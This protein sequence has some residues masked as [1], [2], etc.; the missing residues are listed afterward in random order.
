[1][2]VFDLLYNNSKAS[3]DLWKEYTSA[4]IKIGLN[5][6]I[7]KGN[8][9]F[10][11][12]NEPAKSREVFLT[13][14]YMYYISDQGSII[15]A[16]LK[17]RLIES[18]YEESSAGDKQFG[19][20]VFAG[21][22]R[23]DFYTRTSD[24]LNHWLSQLSNVAIMADFDSEYVCIKQIDA[25]QYGEVFLCQ[26][27]I[28]KEYYAVKKINKN[29]FSNPKALKFLYN[30]IGIMRKLDH[31]NIVKLYKV[32]EDNGFVYMIMEYCPHGNLLK[33]INQCKVFTERESMVFIKNLLE[34]L[35]YLHDKGIIH[36]DLKPE[37]I[38]M[39][40]K[41][42]IYTFK[43]ADFGLSCY[44]DASEKTCSGSPGYMAPEILRGINYST[45]ADIFSAGVIAHIL[46][47]GI[48]PFMAKS[49][50][51]VIE[52]NARCRIM[53][54]LPSFRRLS[55]MAIEFLQE[56]LC[57]DPASR[58]SADQ[59]MKNDWLKI[60]KCSDS[61]ATTATLAKN[62]CF[63]YRDLGNFSIGIDKCVKN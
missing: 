60:R 54:N 58:P 41:N 56:L 18:F 49:S 16:S 42:S 19:F 53:F 15:K 25:G 2:S 3:D 44:L 24:G 5:P 14:S 13:T 28:T 31:E 45:K 57:A 20:S 10:S 40:S 12:K 27:L 34:T 11:Y 59:A 32:Y 55:I 35:E 22:K 23:Y 46:L 38:L 52:K 61:D 8:L 21:S 9:V 63:N 26:D 29:L 47:T 50:Q 37:N 4:N 1:M 7:K 6:V 48:S 36:R 51:K 30:E 43:I 33:R 17:W 39:A 62:D